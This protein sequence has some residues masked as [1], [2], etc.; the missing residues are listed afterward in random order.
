VVAVT[1][2]D[3][4]RYMA[5]RGD[6]DRSAVQTS[7]M[8]ATIHIKNAKIYDGSG[9]ASVSGDV[10]VDGDR[11]TGVGDVTLPEGATTIDANGLALAPGFIDVHTHDDAYA[12]LKPEMPAKASQGVT[13]VVIGNCGYSLAPYTRTSPPDRTAQLM[14]VDEKTTFKSFGDYLD[15]LSKD[16]PSVNVTALAGHI[17]LRANAMEDLSKPAS[18]KELDHMKGELKGALDD[19]AIGLS[20]G[21]YYPPA[22]AAPTQE[23]ATLAE[24]LTAYDGIYTAHIRDEAEHV[25][26][27]M[28]EAAAI[29]AHADVQLVLSHHKTHGAENFGR[30]METLPLIDKLRENGRV[31]LDVYPYTASSTFLIKNAVERSSKVLI[32][33]CSPYPEYSGRDLA[34]IAAEL[35]TNSLDAVDQLTP[36]GA[37]YFSM[38]E[39]DVR[40]VIK[41]PHAMIGSDGLPWDKHP[42]PR[43]WGT[44]PRVLGHYARDIGLIP[45]EDAVHRMTGLPAQQFG[46][47]GRGRIE[48]GAFADL[49]LFDPDTIKDA[50]TFEKPEAPAEGI[51]QVWVNGQTVWRDGAHTGARPG[52]P[53]RRQETSRGKN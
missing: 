10:L 20:T 37:V 4:R 1:L 49:V 26:D 51:A 36:A 41:Y 27:A 15:R 16:Q 30:T 42:H 23:V 48:P 13:T 5:A 21:L 12:L 29:A 11:I 44:F 22:S 14:A 18:A 34:E 31:G 9:A 45:L 53:I 8:T 3:L 43:L 6:I 52:R 46:L 28:E 35:G 7:A 39:A 25:T 50:A 47:E 17:T 40:R 38:D 2:R 32:T 19:G 24:T 33:W